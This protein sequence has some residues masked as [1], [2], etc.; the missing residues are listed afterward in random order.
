MKRKYLI[1][2]LILLT[3]FTVTAVSAVEDTNISAVEDTDVNTI[4]NSSADDSIE[5][6]S[7]DDSVVGG[8]VLAVDDTDDSPDN[9]VVDDNDVLTADNASVDEEEIAQASESDDALKSDQYDLF[10]IVFAKEVSIKN[11]DATVVSFDWPDW[12]PKMAGVITVKVV[13]SSVYTQR[14]KFE[15]THDTIQ[16]SELG[17][18]STGTYSLLFIYGDDEYT[19]VGTLKVSENVAKPKISENKDITMLYTSDTKYKVRIT[20][21]GNAVANQYVTFKFNGKTKKIKTDSKGYATYKLPKVAP[22]TAK[23][24]ITATYK[25]VKVSNKVKVNGIIVSKNLNVKKSSK[26]TKV[27]VTLKKVNKKYL[28]GKKLTLKFKG[29]IY[30]ATTNKKGVAIFKIKKNVFNKLKVGKKYKYTVTY[31]KNTES[32]LFII[33]K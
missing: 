24:T 7:V 5:D 29:K 19:A 31:G 1:V 33:K 30:K 17:I 23:Y 8:D 16:L 11:K 20:L 10:H 32:K 26:V 9:Q 15:N 22:K 3:I 4:E 12:V 25:D 21:A 27:K 14:G 18:T 6:S 28:N 13:G 2:G